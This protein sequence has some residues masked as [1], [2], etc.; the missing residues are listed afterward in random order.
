MSE[1]TPERLKRMAQRLFAQHGVDGVSVRDI[2]SAAGARNNGSLHYYFGSK[3]G[4][5]RELVGDGARR[6]DRRRLEAMQAIEAAGGP[7]TVRDVVNVL[8]QSTV[9]PDDKDA[10]VYLRFVSAVQVSR[11]DL[12]PPVRG[13]KGSPGL[14]RCLDHIRRLVPAF[15]QP[16]IEQRLEL[17]NLYLGAALSE[18]QAAITR[19]RGAGGAWSSPEMLEQLVDTLEAALCAPVAG[20]SEGRTPRAGTSREPVSTA[21]AHVPVGRR[22]LFG[23]ALS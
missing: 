20:I 15:I 16:L 11:R 4:L 7:Y 22:F 12:L 10:E 21:L 3:E 17:M 23:A 14:K 18:R 6:L 5:I 19:R 8:V 2:V 9:T 13:A 1:D